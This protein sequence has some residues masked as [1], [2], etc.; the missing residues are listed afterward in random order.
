M[1]EQARAEVQKMV[2]DALRLSA[3]ISTRKLGDTPTDD[4]QLTPKGYVDTGDT[5][6]TNSVTSTLAA[7][8]L[9]VSADASASIVSLESSVATLTSSVIGLTTSVAAISF[10]VF[11]N[12]SDGVALFDGSASVNGASK[13]GAIY[14][15][16]RDVY[17]A[18]ASVTTAS[19]KTASYQLFVKGTTAISTTG[20][21]SH[22]GINGGPANN[23]NNAS[24]ASG[25]TGGG[26]GGGCS[27][28]GEGT[29]AS[30]FGGLGGGA[31]GN[32]A[33]GANGGTTPGAGLSG[34]SITHSI[35][36]NGNGGVSNATRTGGAA[37][38]WGGGSG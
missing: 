7:S 22:N 18:H 33:S 5:N 3:D 38:A 12:G 32:G 2:D 37:G 20:V 6:V 25:G 9:A 14:T 21:V 17:Y 13:S 23:G 26:G 11:G 4:K 24:G 29:F 8:I 19:V 36:T 30:V 34:A 35:G 10:N 16:T 27:V 1:D 15:L 31:G 28:L